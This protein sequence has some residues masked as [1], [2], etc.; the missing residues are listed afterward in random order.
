[1]AARRATQELQRRADRL[2]WARTKWPRPAKYDNNLVVIDDLKFDAPKT[3]DMAAIIK[4]LKCDG[5]S[6]LVTT[7]GYDQNVY[8]S[9]RNIDQV[10]VSP[11]S[12][13]KIS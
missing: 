10:D 5:A 6:L 9:A 7:A 13:L 3:R 11:V 4:A 1:M 2:G 8:K 12:G